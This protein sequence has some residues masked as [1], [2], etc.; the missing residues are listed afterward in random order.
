MQLL[1]KQHFSPRLQDKIKKN[2]RDMVG[3]VTCTMEKGH[4]DGFH[5]NNMAYQVHTHTCRN[6][7]VI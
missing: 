1:L 6:L 4:M 5:N 7:K 2:D 3:R